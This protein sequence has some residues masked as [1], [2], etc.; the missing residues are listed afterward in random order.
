MIN[1]TLINYHIDKYFSN[2]NIMTTENFEKMQ[3]FQNLS[4]KIN[5][6][7]YNTSMTDEEKDKVFNNDIE[8]I[9]D[10]IKQDWEILKLHYEGMDKARKNNDNM[11]LWFDFREVVDY[12]DM[13]K[14]NIMRFDE[15]VNKIGNECH[16]VIPEKYS[17]EFF[18]DN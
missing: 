18:Y 3:I 6:F 17:L 2:Y 10:L 7:Y 4:I 14:H 15:C 1:N 5:E 11:T 9:F 16:D 13:L 8:E 12:S